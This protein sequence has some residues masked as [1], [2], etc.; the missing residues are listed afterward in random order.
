MNRTELF[1][2]QNDGDVREQ[3][4]MGLTFFR[5]GPS[6]VSS[7]NQAQ[8]NKRQNEIEKG[9]AFLIILELLAG[10]FNNA[11]NFQDETARLEGP[12]NEEMTLGEQIR[13]PN[14]Q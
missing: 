10:H 5:F 11:N 6:V 7:G 3:A 1:G 2:L 4:R 9:G 14:I 12:E 13:T 8:T